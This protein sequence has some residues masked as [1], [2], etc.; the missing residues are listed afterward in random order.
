MIGY[1]QVGYRPQQEKVAVIE[2]DLNDAPLE[3]AVTLPLGTFDIPTPA[4]TKV[5]GHS[6]TIWVRI[7]F[8]L[9]AEAA[10]DGQTLLFSAT[11]P[12]APT[13][14]ARTTRSSSPS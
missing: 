13:G 2:L 9:V 1:S 6:R 11:M 10:P 5:D 8:E 7:S 14:T 3:S 12:Q 4:V